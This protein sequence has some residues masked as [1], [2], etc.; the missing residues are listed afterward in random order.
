ME[1]Y[2]KTTSIAGLQWE[3]F[4]SLIFDTTNLHNKTKPQLWKNKITQTQTTI[5]NNYSKDYQNANFPKK[6]ASLPHLFI[7]GPSWSKILISPKLIAN[8]NRSRRNQKPIMQMRPSFKRDAEGVFPKLWHTQ[9]KSGVNHSFALGL[10]FIS[11]EK[12]PHLA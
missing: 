4:H 10:L 8:N 12:S 5:N 7:W 11:E 9:R 6:I 2:R 3:L 1:N